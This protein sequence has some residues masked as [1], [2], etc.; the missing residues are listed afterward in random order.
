VGAARTA[1]ACGSTPSTSTPK[2]DWRPTSAAPD[3]Q[4]VVFVDV[5]QGSGGTDDGDYSAIQVLD[6]VTHTQV[7]S[8]RSRVPMHDLPLL[9]YLVGLYYNDAWVAVEATGLGIGVL[10]ALAKDYRY[11]MLYRRHRAGDDERADARERVLGWYTDV[12][13]K[14]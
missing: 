3:G 6:H 4:Y 2:P 7:A 5:A 1:S 12:R 11:R 10:D 13:T 8:Y 9:A 14:R